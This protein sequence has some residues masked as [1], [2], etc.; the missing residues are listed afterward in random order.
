MKNATK[1]P[2]EWVWV[3]YVWRENTWM[4]AGFERRKRSRKQ[5]RRTYLFQRVRRKLGIGKE[6]N[7]RLKTLTDAQRCGPGGPPQAFPVDRRHLPT[8]EAIARPRPIQR[9]RRRVVERVARQPGRGAK[10]HV[11]GK[12]PG[13]P[14][15][16]V[17]L[18]GVSGKNAEQA[19]AQAKA[20]FGGLYGDHLWVVQYSVLP[21][22]MRLVPGRTLVP[23]HLLSGEKVA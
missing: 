1:A 22:R 14:V 15:L 9:L 6:E 19:K 18:G 20:L 3:V 10:Y 8:P 4:L 21:P 17:Y 13:G 5:R 7:I 12:R 11:C 23:F 2:L 16:P